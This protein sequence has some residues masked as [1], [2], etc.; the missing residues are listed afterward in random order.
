MTGV[1]LL[2]EASAHGVRVYRVGHR[3]RWRASTPIPSALY[4]RLRE[5]KADLL[6]LLPD[7]AADEAGGSWRLVIEE[8][9][10]VPGPIRLNCCT[11][12][13][14][15]PRCIEKTLVELELALVHK[16]AGRET[17]FT[18]LIDEYIERLA[19]CGCHVRVE[20]LS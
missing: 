17:A 12:I 19:A 7:H 8:H 16:N 4:D 2:D 9:C 5:H 11:T 3:L 15:A 20:P 18:R 13:T 14:D 6:R 1:A 10:P